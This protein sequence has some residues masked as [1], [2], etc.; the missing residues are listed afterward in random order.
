MQ[1]NLVF[2]GNVLIHVHVPNVDVDQDEV[3]VENRQIGGIVEVEVEDLAVAA[4]IAAKVDQ[5]TLVIG[6]SG[7]ESGGQIGPGLRG[8]R[9]DVASSGVRGAGGTGQQGS[10]Q[11]GQPEQLDGLHRETLQHQVCH[12]RSL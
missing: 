1:R 4:P 12:K 7:L 11:T 8:V 10:P 6:R 2:L 5:D 3:G 9:I